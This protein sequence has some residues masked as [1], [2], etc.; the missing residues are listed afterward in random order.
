[1][2]NTD[3]R[4]F[5]VLFIL[6]FSTLYTMADMALPV[7]KLIQLTD[8]TQTEATL[9]GDEHLHFYETADGRLALPFMGPVCRWAEVD[10]VNRLWTEQAAP[11]RREAMR[12]LPHGMA[13]SRQKSS[14]F[15]GTKRGL[16]VLVNFQD[17]AFKTPAPKSAFNDLFNKEGYNQD[18]N[19]GSVHDFFYAQSYGQF[20]FQFD[21]VG[22]V[23]LSRG[24]SYYGGDQ[25]ERHDVNAGDMV[26]E[27]C[28][29]LDQYVDFS[30]YDWD[31]DGEVDMVFFVYAGYGQNSGA[32]EETIWPHQWSVAN[33]KLTLDGVSIA[34]YACSPEL[35]GISGT[36]MRGVG[37]PCHE[38]THCFGIRDH[39]DT[40]Y[41]GNTGTGDWDIMASGDHLGEGH[42]PC[43]YNAFER[44]CIGW[45]DLPE[46]SSK[47]YVSQMKPL[48]ANPEAYVICNDYNRNEYYIVENRQ[49]QGWD[50]S[51]RGHGMLVFHVDYDPYYWYSNRVNSGDRQ[52]FSIIAADGTPCASYEGDPFPGKTGK[53][54]LTDTTFPKAEVF[55]PGPD[56]Y[57][58]MGKPL[59]DIEEQDGL[60]SFAFMRDAL[61]IP[62]LN[63]PDILSPSSFTLSWEPV[64]GATSYTIQM[65]EKPKP[66]DTPEEACIVDERF[67]KCYSKSAGINN[68]AKTLDKYTVTPGWTGAQLYTSPFLLKMGKGNSLGSITTPQFDTPLADDLTIV[69]TVKPYTAGTE[70]KTYLKI[71]VGDRT[72]SASLKTKEEHAFLVRASDVDGPFSISLEPQAAAYLSRFSIYDGYFDGSQVGVEDDEEEEDE[73]Q[74]SSPAHVRRNARTVTEYTTTEPSYTFSDLVST[75]TFYVMVKAHTEL[76]SSKWSKQIEVK[77][78]TNDDALTPVFARPANHLWYDLQGRP[79]VAPTRSG[80]YIKDGKKIFCQ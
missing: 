32:P 20:D 50:A 23:N 47:T 22:P 25:D 71:L 12:K 79:T 10:E 60:I 2:R 53:T 44:W 51:L 56:G 72:L 35:S 66:F 62:V 63:D 39:Y 46:L 73:N 24:M 21:V 19:T 8:G 5:A 7:K 33:S 54:Q 64:E 58:Y 59:T 75:S 6:L 42:T 61:P 69:F 68:I 9:R 31:G 55:T 74:E 34:T 13:K 43:G 26:V 48:D 3:K 76:G 70:L 37:T 15:V 52:H 78:G 40:Q 28:K 1:M 14:P 38:F 30:Q 67:A 77:P 41:S 18:G 29:Q 49:Q 36:Q 11:A 16:V 27:S 4:L 17:V 65:I 80:F 57:A 45:M